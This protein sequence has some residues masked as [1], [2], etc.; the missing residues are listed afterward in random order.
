MALKGHAKFQ[1]QLDGLL[2][3]FS[4]PAEVEVIY[5]ASSILNGWF[6][7]APDNIVGLISILPEVMNVWYPEKYSLD[8]PKFQ[9]GDV[10]GDG[11]V[12]SIDVLRLRQH[13]AGWKVSIN[14]DNADTNGDGKVDAMDVLRLRQYLAN[15]QVELGK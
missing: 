7:S 13:L 9:I 5:K 12:N 3:S 10:N 4:I 1:K 2:A 15:W 8:Q 14:R 11:E 6:M